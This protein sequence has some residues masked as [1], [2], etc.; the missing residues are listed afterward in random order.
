MGSEQVATVLRQ[1]GTHVR[2]VVAR[3][4]DPTSPE[5]KQISSC[6]P[7]VPTRYNST[8][9]VCYKVFLIKQ[10]KENILVVLCRV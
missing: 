2:L 8:I 7:L 3:P 6:A 4:A 10:N 9:H 1:S 5:Y